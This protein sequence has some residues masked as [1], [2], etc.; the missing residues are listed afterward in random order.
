MAE[1]SLRAYKFRLYPNKLQILGLRKH[2]WISK[3]LWNKL[4]AFC[5]GIYAKTKRFP[6][7][8]ELQLMVKGFGLYSQTQ[9]CVSHRVFESIK[10][11]FTLKKKGVHCGFPRFKSFHN[12]KSLYYPQSGFKLGKKLKVTPFGEI[13]IRKHRKIKG[14]IKTL[15]LKL[16]PTGKWYAVF[17]VEVELEHRVNCGGF[18]GVDLGLKSFAS[19][20]DGLIIQNPH[21]FKKYESKLSFLQRNL[22]RCKKDSRNRNKAKHKVALLHEKV[23]NSRRDFLHKLS[24]SLVSKYSL[25]ALE[26]L[27]PKEMSEQQLGKSIHDAGWS[28]FSN[29]LCY[30]AESA[31]SRIVFVNPKDTTKECSECGSLSKKNLQDRTHNC[32]ICGFS[33]DRDLNAAKVILKRATAGLAEC[34]ACGVGTKSSVKEARNPVN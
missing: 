14:R 11:M 13:A 32:P 8:T 27:N 17:T 7:K 20:S 25:I 16:E 33:L 10:R 2:L 26:K 31:G 19:L 4:L 1:S 23:G 34:N 28:M 21:H 6:K 3:N 9:Q 18:V 29:M 15:S 24:A 5:K 22:S 30:K 12:M